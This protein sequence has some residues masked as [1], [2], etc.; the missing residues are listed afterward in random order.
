[1]IS[2]NGVG[3]NVPSELITLIFPAL[4]AINERLSPQFF[5]SIGDESPGV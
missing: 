2:R 4:P 3:R 1:M 5:I